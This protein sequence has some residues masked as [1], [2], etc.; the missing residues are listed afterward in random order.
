[1][2]LSQQAHDRLVKQLASRLS[3]QSGKRASVYRTHIS[4]VIVC[5]KRAYKLKRPVK[6]PFVDFSTLTLRHEDCERETRINRLAAPALYLGVVKIT[7][8]P[9]AP[10]INGAGPT[11]DWAVLMRRFDQTALLSHLIQYDGIS[12]QDAESLGRYVAHQISQRPALK[13]HI[14]EGHR[15]A[16]NWLQESLNEITGIYADLLPE[17]S[18]IEQ[19]AKSQ[20][21]QH[22]TLIEQRRKAGYYRDCHGDLHLGNL[23]KLGKNIVAFD[24]LEF[25]RDLSQIDVINDVAFAFMDFLAHGRSD[26]AWSMINQW[27][28]VTKDYE[29]LLLLRYYTLYRAVVR[30]KVAA[31]TNKRNACD[32]SFERYWHL[33][34]RLVKPANAPRL[35]IVAGLSGSGKSTV[36]RA[37]VGKWSAI[38]LRADIIRK[39]LFT[40]LIN[41]PKRLYSKDASRRTYANLASIADELLKQNLTVL[42]DATFLVQEHVDQFS[43]LA[44]K[45]KIKLEVI[46]CEAPLP[47]MKRRIKERAKLGRDP[48]DADA[49]VLDQQVRQ[50]ESHP[51]C[52]PNSP[53]HVDTHA[54]RAEVRRYIGQLA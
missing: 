29:A 23:L 4:S 45:H 11:L 33:A 38:Q 19:W 22:H 32:E 12:S 35:I 42:V 54:T 48:S 6:L 5:G 39:H 1:M 7:G 21:T 16:L 50:L 37:L 43:K 49:S 2:N 24:A 18:A 53:H 30:A 44:D 8:T 25:N 27:C 15:P 20:A 10:R 47:I 41:D 46:W 9:E 36:A 28:E 26:L 52:W 31:L 3:K 13:V 40:D 17:A 51:V 14:T 34:N